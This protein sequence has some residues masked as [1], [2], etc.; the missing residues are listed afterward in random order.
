MLFRVAKLKGMRV[1]FEDLSLPVWPTE[2]IALLVSQARQGKQPVIEFIYEM[3]RLQLSPTWLFHVVPR[4]PLST[5]F[6]RCQLLFPIGSLQLVQEGWAKTC[7]A[8]YCAVAVISLRYYQLRSLGMPYH[9]SPCLQSPG[10]FPISSI[11]LP[12][13]I[14]AIFSPGPFFDPLQSC[15]LLGDPY[16]WPSLLSRTLNSGFA[17]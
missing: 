14:F 6:S 15:L 12:A 1:H 9:L 13:T 3:T 2:G 5:T 10:S 4:S 8:L 17:F 7:Q 16:F 11:F